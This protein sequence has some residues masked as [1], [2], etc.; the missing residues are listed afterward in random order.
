MGTRL[1]ALDLAFL[2]L[3]TQNSPVNVAGL[4]VFHIPKGYKGNF[5]RKLLARLRDQTAGPP[6]DRKL[7]STSPVVLPEWI[8][9]ENFDLEYH[10]RHSALPK[11]G[12]WNDL[13]ALASRLHSRVMDRERPLWEF[14]IIEGL[15]GG[16][17]AIYMKMHHAAI[18]G[19]GGIEILEN[20][21]SEDENAP[22]YAPWRGL[23]KKRKKK[24]VSYGLIERAFKTTKQLVDQAAL[25]ADLGRLLMGHG[26][27]TVGLK[28][29]NSPVPFTAPKSILNVPIS[30]ARRFAVGSLSLGRIRALGKAAGTTVNDVILATCAGALRAY[31]VERDALPEESLLANVPVSIRQINR[32]GN[33][34]T[35]IGARLCTDQRDPL[36]RLKG[37]G[38]STRQAKQEVD[39]V[40]PAAAI[41]FAVLAQGLVAVLNRFR[42]SNLL[43]PPANVTISNVPGPRK[44]L[45]F[46]GALMAANYPLSVLV[47]GQ[48]LNITV[49]SYCDAVDFGLMACRDAMPDLNHMAD[50]ILESFEELEQAVARS[51]RARPPARKK[52]TLRQARSGKG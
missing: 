46:G 29:D 50:L 32:S 9:D 17:F 28:P 43:P 20:C 42:I 12:T 47:D 23:E 8:K 27:K 41:T 13:V 35:Y 34:I 24:R 48:A 25:S 37:I 14:H 26:M 45:Y 6:F 4:G 19:M 1:T 51:A 16:R 15:S 21:Y 38:L 3:E 40:S 36:K 5:V 10:V 44:P 11:P 33:Q 30:G 22:L 18:D 2:A 52:K 7:S 39:D 49:I 31:L